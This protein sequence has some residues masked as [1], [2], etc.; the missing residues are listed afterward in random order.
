MPVSGLSAHRRA[1]A[2]VGEA[3]LSIN[4]GAG[5]DFQ[6]ALPE[7]RELQNAQLSLPDQGGS[8]H[9]PRAARVPERRGTPRLG[10][11]APR[12]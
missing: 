7:R 9:S 12:L 11:S 4:V 1:A 5:G 2:P 8:L 6:S 3:D 10:R